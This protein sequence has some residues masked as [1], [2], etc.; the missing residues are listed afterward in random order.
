MSD[1]HQKLYC[2]LAAIH[3]TGLYASSKEQNKIAEYYVQQS[4]KGNS[5]NSWEQTRQ[6]CIN[7]RVLEVVPD[8]L[9]LDL[10]L[11]YCLKNKNKHG[12]LLIS[13]INKC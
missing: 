11:L 3:I 6:K 1:S 5:P 8:R 13:M 12:S 7:N 2:L 9:L 4:L 10:F